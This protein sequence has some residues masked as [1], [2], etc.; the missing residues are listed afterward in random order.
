VQDARH[1][2]AHIQTLTRAPSASPFLQL[3]PE[4]IQPGAGSGFIWDSQ[5]VVTNFHVVQR[6]SQVKATLSNQQTYTATVVGSDPNNDIAVLKLDTVPADVRPISVGMSHDLMVG[7]RVF[8]IG[9]PF[10]LDQ[11]LTGAHESCAAPA[12]PAW[13]SVPPRASMP[14]LSPAFKSRL[15]VPQVGCARW[16]PFRAAVQRAS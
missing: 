11:T 1:S 8:A 5:H 4:H 10:G 15:V 13:P 3:N 7:Q 6:A 16:S 12:A 14:L 2:V 9:N